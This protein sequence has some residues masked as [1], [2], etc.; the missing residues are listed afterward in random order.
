MNANK[1]EWTRIGD[2]GF[3]FVSFV[4]IRAI[5]CLIFFSIL[6][7]AFTGC[8]SR[9]ASAEEYFAIGMAY[10]DL[11]KFEDAEKWLNRAKSV[12]KT[13]NASEYN[14]G[15]I[16]FELKRY[17]DASK[18]FEGILKRDPG[19]VPALKAAAYTRIRNGEIEKAEALYARL[20]AL[21]PESADD[22]YNYA[23][24]LFAMKKYPEAE[25]VLKDHEFALLDNNDVLLLYARCQKEQHKPEAIDTYAQWLVNNNDAKVRYEYA[26][27][28]EN[29]E[30][31][32]KALGEYR[33]ALT[34]LPA[35]GVNPSKPEIRFAVARVLM[36]ADAENA[37]GLT[38]LKGAVED[39]FK[40]LEAL[41]GLLENEKINA[42]NKEG[43]KEVIT[44]IKVAKERAEKEAEDA[45]KTAA[46]AAAR[47]R[48][49]EEESGDEKEGGEEDGV[50]E[51]E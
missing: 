47:A 18:H 25:Q 7:I 32:A 14:L 36:I 8:A 48:A 38:E 22:G 6:V 9:A 30:M 16:A 11:G 27:L 1:D 39:G 34:D 23:L 35:T 49:V 31:Y 19:N 28:L 13:K 29:A 50:P 40:D 4:I 3:S 51:A 33:T 5:R 21:V 2:S 15:R 20:L 26:G 12:D 42:A 46:E 45:A 44:E 17:E 37:E 41:E 10:Y 43:I 24:V